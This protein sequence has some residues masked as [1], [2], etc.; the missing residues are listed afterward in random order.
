MAF[1]PNYGRDRAER[2]RAARARSEEKKRKRDE[3]TALRKAQRAEVEPP[4][5][6]TILDWTKS[7]AEAYAPGAARRA[8]SRLHSVFAFFGWN[9]RDCLLWKALRKS[10]A[11]RCVLRPSKVAPAHRVSQPNLRGVYPRRRCP[12]C[13]MSGHF[14]KFRRCPMYPR[15]RTSVERLT[16]SALCQKRNRVMQHKLDEPGTPLRQGRGAH[17]KIRPYSHAQMSTSR[18]TSEESELRRNR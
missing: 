12:L 4:T 14:T 10:A 9:F 8:P 3:K 2:A 18:S 5:D 6:E 16:M 7:K 15:K 17:E 13:V 1:K 11:V